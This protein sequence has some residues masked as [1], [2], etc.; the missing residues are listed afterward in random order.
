MIKMISGI[1]KSKNDTM[2]K[3]IKIIVFLLLLYL[4]FCDTTYLFRNVNTSRRSICGMVDNLD[5]VY[6][7]GSDT[8]TYYQPLRAWEEFGFTS[9]NYTAESM[10]AE[11]IKY[12]IREVLDE[13]TV[14]PDLFVVEVRPFAKWEAYQSSYV[15]DNGS[16]R[17]A[18]DA[19]DLSM[20]RLQLLNTTLN[21]RGVDGWKERLPYYLDLML[22][23]Q[24]YEALSNQENWKYINNYEE[25]I[26][27]GY[28]R[29]VAGPLHS[30]VEKPIKYSE[31]AA[32]GEIPYQLLLDL[33]E[34][35]SSEEIEVLFVASPF[36]AEAGSEIFQKINGMKTLINSYG[37]TLLDTNEWVDEMKLDFNTDFQNSGHANCFGAEKY[38]HFL[39]EYIVKNYELSD[40]RSD[41][42]YA[43][44]NSYYE[45]FIVYIS[46]LEEETL[47]AIEEHNAS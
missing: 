13:Q 33:L 17:F 1:K 7:G 14:R 18:T 46:S 23:R 42:A 2:K 26:F 27:M 37:Y 19:M 20:N 25:N 8:F 12:L 24:N 6:I 9:Y 32:L 31:E 44:W 34:F 35:C 40:H 36:G 21:L 16:I 29:C 45:D 11:A 47:N 4:I 22:F 41:I 15:G 28:D 5:M 3:Q 10:Q 38:T 39:S 30:R 43:K